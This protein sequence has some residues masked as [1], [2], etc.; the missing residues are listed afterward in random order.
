M[1]TPGEPERAYKAQRLVHGVP[2]DSVTWA[3][4]I[5]AGGKV[6]LNAGDIEALARRR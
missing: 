3:E 1:L 2:V 5:A 4:I 6:G